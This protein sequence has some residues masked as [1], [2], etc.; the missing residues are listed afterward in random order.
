MNSIFGA[1]LLGAA[2]LVGSGASAATVNLQGNATAAPSFSTSIDGVGL[3][4][5]AYRNN[6][7]GGGTTA[8]NVTQSLTGGLG[9]TYPLDNTADLDGVLDE[10]LV[11]TFASAVK[12]SSILFGNVDGND[13]WDLWIDNGTGFAQVAFDSDLN[14]YLFNDAVVTSLRI[15]ADGLNDNFRVKEL[16]AV[17]AVP[18]PAA[19]FLLIGALGGLA[20]MRRRKMAA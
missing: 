5:T 19:G 4:V 7:F 16:N 10:F 9:A 12:L 15:G 17:A 11:F 14:P 20:A 8:I 2:V 3:T 1:A 13:D 6:L 18:L